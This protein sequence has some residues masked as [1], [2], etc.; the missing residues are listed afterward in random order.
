MELFQDIQ[1]KEGRKNR[2]RGH[3]RGVESGGVRAVVALCVAIN[4]NAI[5]DYTP[6]L[7]DKS[8]PICRGDSHK[9]QNSSIKWH[10]FLSNNYFP[11]RW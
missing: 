4:N 1:L 7:T 11:K 5:G 2:E 3:G 8:F 6:I 10:I 9:T